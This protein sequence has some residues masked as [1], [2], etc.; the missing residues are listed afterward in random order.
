LDGTV[1][2]RKVWNGRA[3]LA[4]ITA[5]SPSGKL[6]FLSLRLFNPKSQ[7]WSLN[8]ASSNS[9][10]LSTP[11]V[12]AFKNGR[13]EFYDQEPFDGR[14]IW[15]RFVFGDVTATSNRDEQAF[16]D[17]GGRTWEINWINT[18]TRAVGH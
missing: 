3:N 11:M 2:V 17:D 1:V 8:F 18:S 15:V 9:G 14:M 12:G 13:G 10:T 5:D 7:Q 6:E 16:S 4:E